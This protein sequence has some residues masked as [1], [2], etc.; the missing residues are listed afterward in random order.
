MSTKGET[1]CK[2]LGEKLREAREEAK[3]TQVEVAKKADMDVNYYA[4]IERGLGNPSYV[5][6]YSIMKALKM[7]SLN[8]E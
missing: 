4:R 7:K 3:L 2:E 5:K 6:L 1:I 8:I